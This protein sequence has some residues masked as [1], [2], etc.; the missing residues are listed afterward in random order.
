MQK[1]TVSLPFST[2]TI[3]LIIMCYHA[4]LFTPRAVP[5]SACW[6]VVYKCQ[7][8]VSAFD[9]F[10]H[11]LVCGWQTKQRH[12]C[13]SLRPP[14]PPPTLRKGCFYHTKR[15]NFKITQLHNYMENIIKQ[16]TQQTQNIS[17]TVKQRWPN[18][19]R[20]WSNIV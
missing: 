16:Q 6:R 15:T 5:L 3:N 10:N 20:R 8:S 19:L 18:I 9:N 4:L 7:A 14:P 2:I 12:Q 1:N 13:L 11:F 17:I